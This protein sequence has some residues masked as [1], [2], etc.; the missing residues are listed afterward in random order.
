MIRLTSQWRK[1]HQAAQTR[2]A[3]GRALDRSSSPGMDQ[4]LMILAS[5]Q[6]IDVPR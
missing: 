4:E 6:F 5:R 3:I 1:R 2:R